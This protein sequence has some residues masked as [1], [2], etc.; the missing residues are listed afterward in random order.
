[1]YCDA[2][3]IFAAPGDCLFCA[4]KEPGLLDGANTI[5]QGLIQI[6]KRKATDLHMVFLYTLPVS[7]AN[8]LWIALSSSSGSLWPS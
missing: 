1:M 2:P 5:H 3:L 7:Q 8:V 4:C 6:T